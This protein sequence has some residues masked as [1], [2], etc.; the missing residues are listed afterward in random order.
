MFERAILTVQGTIFS[1]EFKELVDLIL[2]FVVSTRAPERV[3][4]ALLCCI[5]CIRNAH[6]PVLSLFCRMG[7][8]SG[9]RSECQLG[10]HNS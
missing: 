4:V 7:W 6:C 5:P 10:D 1:L 9:K 2:G 8:R 3:K